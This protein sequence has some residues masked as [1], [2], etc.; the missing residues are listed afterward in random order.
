MAIS[1]HVRLPADVSIDSEIFFGPFA[2]GVAMLKTL[3][4]LSYGYGDA[5]G[6]S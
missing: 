1:K 2:G 5:P 6:A 4:A 3:F